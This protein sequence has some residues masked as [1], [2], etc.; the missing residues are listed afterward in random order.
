MKEKSARPQVHFSFFVFTI[1][2]HL[3]LRDVE[4]QRESKC[5]KDKIPMV[6][7]TRTPS[8]RAHLLCKYQKDELYVMVSVFPIVIFL[9]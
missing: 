6:R 5:G 8:H 7:N 3:V 4:N 1:N 9:F 2:G